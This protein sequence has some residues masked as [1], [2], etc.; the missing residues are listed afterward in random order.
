MTGQRTARRNVESPL[1]RDLVIDRVT[2]L[3]SVLVGLVND[4]R[5]VP[6]FGMMEGPRTNQ[7]VGVIEITIKS[8]VLV[9]IERQNQRIQKRYRTDKNHRRVVELWRNRRSGQGLKNC[10]IFALAW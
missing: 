4:P 8:Q 10:R 2:D 5:T 9:R 7:I 3:V 6:V 1:P